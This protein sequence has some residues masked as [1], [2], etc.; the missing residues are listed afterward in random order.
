MLELIK[1]E[2]RAFS[3][4]VGVLLQ[5]VTKPL[6]FLY[7][8]SYSFSLSE[9]RIKLISIFSINFYILL[10]GSWSFTLA[11]ISIWL[12]CTAKVTQAMTFSSTMYENIDP[13]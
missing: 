4:L 7:A 2:I 8:K 6:R 10:A 3:A 5:D 1:G 9:K 13:H 11:H 12:V